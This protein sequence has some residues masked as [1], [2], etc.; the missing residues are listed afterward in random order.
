MVVNVVIVVSDN[1]GNTYLTATCKK[2]R[3]YF[4]YSSKRWPGSTQHNLEQYKK[5]FQ[6]F[7]LWH[8]GDYWSDNDLLYGIL[9]FVRMPQMQNLLYVIK[10]EKKSKV[11]KS[12]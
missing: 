12:G 6:K 10:H 9:N 4:M 1:H 5:Y 8:I 3:I 2:E 7:H 11:L